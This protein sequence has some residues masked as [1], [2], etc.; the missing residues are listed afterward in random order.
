MTNGEHYNIMNKIIFDDVEIQKL[1][2]SFYII[3]DYQREY[4]WEEKQVRQLLNDIYDQFSSNSDGEYFL[5]TIVTC[6]HEDT[7]KYEVID[8]Q[9]RLITLSLMLNSFRRLLKNHKQQVN[10]IE[11]LL[12][13]VTSNPKGEAITSSILDIQY[14][15][16]E[17]L[18]DLYKLDLN[19]D[20]QFSLIEGKPGKTIHDAHETIEEFFR[21]Q[22][23]GLEQVSQLKH[24]SGYILN[25]LKIIKIET[26]TLST[27]LKIFETINE[28]GIGL[29]GVDLLKNLLFMQIKRDDFEKLKIDWNKFKKSIQG[30][31]IKER[32]LRFLRYFIM[33]NYSVEPDEKGSKIVRE[34]NVYD[35]FAQSEQKCN[36]KNNSFLFVRKIQENASFYIDLMNNKFHG[37]RSLYLENISFLVG[38]ASKQH[39]ILLLS[40]MNLKQEQF[41][42]FVN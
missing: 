9:Q 8:G 10:H 37:D 14:E 20:I 33:A 18:Y 23:T 31:K 40:A 36:Y 19:E 5:G 25:N 15:G 35:W 24:F 7:N 3:P 41:S 42:F 21:V 1:L 16:K 32:P 11:K 28:R 38:Q 27:A 34:D 2:Q 29:D 12:N 13:S 6:K 17:V 22:F 39:Y 4:V 26:P 30:G